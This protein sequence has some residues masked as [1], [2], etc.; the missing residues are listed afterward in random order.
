MDR[1]QG[2]TA[3]TGKGKGCAGGSG[4]GKGY[5]T[6]TGSKG[7]SRGK[8]K[9]AEEVLVGHGLQKFRVE[10]VNLGGW[11]KR[12]KYVYE[13]NMWNMPADLILCCEVDVVTY[14]Q[15]AQEVQKREPADS[16]E[17]V[18]LSPQGFAEEGC[19]DR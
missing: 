8:G 19:V 17:A 2:N 4:K 12:I 16:P 14:E 1:A 10:R 11:R 9:P 7:N 18:Q 5:G 15:M 6:D 13:W 3:G